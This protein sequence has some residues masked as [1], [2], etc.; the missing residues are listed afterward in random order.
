M[1]RH[2]VVQEALNNRTLKRYGFLMPSD[3]VKLKLRC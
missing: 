3:L 1:A 2:A